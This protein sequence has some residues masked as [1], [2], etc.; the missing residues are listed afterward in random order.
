MLGTLHL[1]C[2]QAPSFLSLIA[3]TRSWDKPSWQRAFGA[4]P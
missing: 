2:S 4:T 1:L 3:S